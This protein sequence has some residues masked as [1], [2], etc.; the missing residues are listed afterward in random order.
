[1]GHIHKELASQL[2]DKIMFDTFSLSTKQ[3]NIMKNLIDPLNEKFSKRITLESARQAAR[4]KYEGGCVIIAQ[5]THQLQNG[6]P[7]A[8]QTLHKLELTR[9]SVKASEE[10]YWRL[11][12]EMKEAVGSWEKDRAEF[13]AALQSA[14]EERI[15]ALRS[16]AWD[17]TNAVSTACVQ[18]DEV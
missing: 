8:P 16:I 1:M 7:D 5:Y 17:Y 9:Q 18:D 12:R 14:E 13:C 6:D 15:D 11:H 4:D 3:D 2:R 10:E